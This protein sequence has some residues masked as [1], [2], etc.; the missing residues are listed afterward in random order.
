MET[1]ATFKY[2]KKDGSSPKSRKVLVISKPSNLLFGVEFDDVTEIDNYLK[3]LEERAN[4]DAYLR[5]KYE[6]SGSKFKKF[7]ADRMIGL[8]E[9]KI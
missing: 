8:I 2:D 7:K 9:S 6:L 1:V 4:F 5:H 3:Y